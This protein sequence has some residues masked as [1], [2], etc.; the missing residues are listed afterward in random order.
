M[1]ASY[2]AHR[3]AGV[4]KQ[5]DAPEHVYAE[6]VEQWR[7]WLMAQ[8]SRPTGTW[9]VSWRKQAHKPRMMYDETVEEALCFGW[10]DSKSGRLDADREM[11]WFAPRRKGSGWSRSNK[12]RILR[13]EADGRVTDAGRAI[14]TQA[15]ADGTWTL[16]DE[17][18]DLI[19]PKDLAKAFEARPGSRAEWES[20]PRSVKRS[21]LEWIVVAKREETR[22]KR[23]EETAVLAQRGERANL[24]TPKHP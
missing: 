12:E 24:W 19:V 1:P 18:E 9:L 20:F 14:V 13:L 5:T 15:K 7:A 3:L 10:I 16:L 17:V 23:I 6:T 2:L 11:L 4:T 8:H 22:R 21:I